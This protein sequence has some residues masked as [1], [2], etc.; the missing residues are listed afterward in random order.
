MLWP[1]TRSDFNNLSPIHSA[2]VMFPK[3]S[4]KLTLREHSGTG[5]NVPQNNIWGNLFLLLFPKPLLRN[6][7]PVPI[8]QNTLEE[9][10]SCSYSPR[11]FWGN[12]FLS[13][14]PKI[15]L[16]N[17]VPVSVPQKTFQELGNC[18]C[19]PIFFGELGNCPPNFGEHASLHCDVRC[20]LCLG[21]EWH[22]WERCE[23]DVVVAMN[24]W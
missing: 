1:L 14:F 2:P 13:L 15:L 9:H 22:G 19:S 20:S 10:L 17:F 18:S 4:P 23:V 7:V 12:F 16:R 24:P 21:Y 11:T 8:P 5:Q 6:I 3:I